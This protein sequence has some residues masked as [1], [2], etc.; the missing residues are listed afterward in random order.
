[1][2]V[3]ISPE[4]IYTLSEVLE[5]LKVSDATLRRWI[6]QGKLKA[7][8]IGRDYR[9]L[10]RDIMAALK[11]TAPNAPNRLEVL[12]KMQAFQERILVARGGRL[13]EGSSADLIREA[14][15]ER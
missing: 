1:M 10:G 4:A 6:K 3:G 15:G 13:L 14:R 9:F 2:A 12:K 5:I 7:H 11:E 8:R